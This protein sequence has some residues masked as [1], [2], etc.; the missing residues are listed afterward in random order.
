MDEKQDDVKV[1]QIRTDN[2]KFDTK[3]DDGYFL[4]YSFVSKFFRVFNTRR[5]QAE[6]TY[7]VTFDENMEAFR[8]YQANF[9]IS[10]YI[11]SHNR[12][13]TEL[14]KTTHVP[15]VITPNE[16]N[17]PHT[18]EIKGPPDL[19]N[20]EWTHEQ[21]VQNE[22]INNQLTKE[23]SGNNAETLVSI[24][25][26]LVPEITQSPITYH[27]SKSLNPAPQDRWNKARLVA[28]GYSQEEG[29]KYDE[30]FTPVVRIEA[31]K[32]FLAYAT[33][34]NF[35]VFQMDVKSAF[36]N[37]KLKE[38]VYVK[39]PPGFKSSEFPDYILNET[40]YR[41]MIESLVYLTTKLKEEVYVKQ[42]PGFK[43]SE[44][45]DYICKLDEAIYGLK[46]EPRA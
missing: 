30:T 27:A 37:R 39:Q 8:Q 45:P 44:F 7:H 15:E 10:Y 4:G 9:N 6:E 12:S 41:G 40:L 38:E 32:I 25:E 1:K 29:I 28:P 22:Q 31:I 35:K 43:S 5:Q 14:I 18:E 17:I 36:L 26:L 34:M 13:L 46:Q 16:Q 21:T 20:T 33:Y 3:A 11:T 2:G 23:H 19:I 42:P 24:T